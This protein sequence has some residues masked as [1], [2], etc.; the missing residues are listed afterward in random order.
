[1]GI[2]SSSSKSDKTNLESITDELTQDEATRVSLQSMKLGEKAKVVV[3]VTS[4][5]ALKIA[6]DSLLASAEISQKGIDTAGIL[7]A[8][9][10]DNQTAL[11]SEGFSGLFDFAARTTRQSNA[12][13]V[14]LAAGPGGSSLAPQILLDRPAAKSEIAGVTLIVMAAV[15]V[16]AV[17]L[18]RR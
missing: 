16:G 5:G 7:A 6:R 3:N 8:R 15:A 14:E 9:N 10:L 13:A 1:M 12:L 18:M 4:T 11:L 17:M 2:F